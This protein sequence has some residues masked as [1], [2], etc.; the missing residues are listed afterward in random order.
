MSKRLSKLL[1]GLAI[2]KHQSLLILSLILLVPEINLVGTVASVAQDQDCS[3]K[4]NFPIALQS[5]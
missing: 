2:K 5:L 1:C 3:V 4:K